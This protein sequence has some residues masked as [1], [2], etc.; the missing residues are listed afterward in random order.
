MK[1]LLKASICLLLLIGCTL[2]FNG[3][4]SNAESKYSIKVHDITDKD[5][6]LYFTLG[7]AD[8]NLNSVYVEINGKKFT[9]Y[10]YSIS[11]YIFLDRTYSEGTEIKVYLEYRKDKSSYFESELVDIIKVKD[12][13]P[14][15]LD[16]PDIDI[17]TNAVSFKTEVG[18]SITATYNGKKL[19]P[20]QTS[21]T[22][23]KLT[24]NKPLVGKKLVIVATDSAGN[25]STITKKTNVPNNIFIIT[26]DIKDSS[27]ISKGR[28][29]ASKS[30]DK[31]YLIVGSKKY[32]G[33]IKSGKYSIKI[34]KI[35]SP[36][37][38]K[39]QLIDRYGNVLLT[40]NTRVY[41][42]DKV[43]IG[44]TENQIL[45]SFYGEPDGITTDTF[46]NEYWEFWRYD[47]GN[48]TTFLNFKNGK[49]FSI[50]KY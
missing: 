13:H 35:K 16:V 4:E 50:S 32:K 41:K 6:I 26:E 3:K 23:W 30:T 9:Q 18:A 31:I 27:K 36:K 48:K 49:L 8:D 25:K 38:V 45:N 28:V 15:T 43:K 10:F 5:K 22:T 21:N 29:Y 1:S 24:I 11:N 33:T 44:M 19:T 17:R 37:T 7:N 20:K 14:P 12:G 2:V 40:E 34:P 39:I 42:Y 46:S 47:K